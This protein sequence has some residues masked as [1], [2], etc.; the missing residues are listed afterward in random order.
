MRTAVALFGMLV[1]YG[2]EQ[3]IGVVLPIES[4]HAAVNDPELV[5]MRRE[6]DEEREEREE[7]EGSGIEAVSDD[8]RVSLAPLGFEEAMRALLATP[9]H[10]KGE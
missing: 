8:D 5:Q 10:P 9:P 1:G 7:A 4:I 2:D 3:G 6:R